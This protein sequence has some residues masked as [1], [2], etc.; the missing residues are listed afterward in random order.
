MS[1]WTATLSQ[2][3]IQAYMS[4]SLSG[5]ESNLVAYWNFNEGTGTTVSDITSNGNDGTISGA[6]WSSDVPVPGCTDPYAVNYN[7]DATWDDGSC[8]YS[9][10]IGTIGPAGGF[11]FFDKGVSTNGWRFLEVAPA[12]WYGN[13]EPRGAWG[14]Y[15]NIISPS[16]SI[17]SGLQNTLN[18]NECSQ[19]AQTVLNTNING[20]DDWFLPSIEEL[21]EI[22]SRLH[23][24]NIGNFNID[25]YYWSSTDYSE[26][27]AYFID[28]NDGSLGDNN[29]NDAT[30]YFRPIRFV[31]EITGCTDPYATNYDETATLDNGSCLFSLDDTSKFTYGG[32]YDGSDYYISSTKE[33]FCSRYT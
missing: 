7:S 26:I 28:F 15:G 10:F 3:E 16:T 5:S 11:I 33:S 13:N 27:G 20:Y 2:S 24:N 25:D 18:M 4:T 22:Y 29:K 14:C 32:T 6:T 31:D 19:I 17:G 30:E 23:Q 9:D 8:E 1:F 12:N 21:N